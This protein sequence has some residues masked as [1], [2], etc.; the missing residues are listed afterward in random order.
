VRAG[1]RNRR[2]IESDPDLDSIRSHAR[3]RAAAA[4]LKDEAGP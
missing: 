2:W 3:Y 4:G 1:F